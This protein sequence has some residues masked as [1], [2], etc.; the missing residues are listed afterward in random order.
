MDRFHMNVQSI[1]LHEDFGFL[2]CEAMSLD[3]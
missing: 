3:E 2:E 1:P